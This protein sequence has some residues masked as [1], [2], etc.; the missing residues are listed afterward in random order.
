M[1]DLLWDTQAMERMFIYEF[2]QNEL[3]D[4]IDIIDTFFESLKF[5][6]TT[7]LFGDGKLR[8]IDLESTFS[9]YSFK[10]KHGM[11]NT[12]FS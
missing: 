1:D 4:G 7:P 6:S 2:Q 3:W 10:V 5:A 9:L 11:S 8:N 12:C